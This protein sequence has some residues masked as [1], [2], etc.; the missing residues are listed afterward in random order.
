M[1]MFMKSVCL[2]SRKDASEVHG[3]DCQEGLLCIAVA[4]NCI[5]FSCEHVSFGVHL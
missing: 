3:R 5:F 1:V 2:A 4:P